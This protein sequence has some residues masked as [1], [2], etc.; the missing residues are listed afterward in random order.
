MIMQNYWREELYTVFLNLDCIPEQRLMTHSTK[1]AEDRV[2]L[3]GH[4]PGICDVNENVK[5][6]TSQNQNI[7]LKKRKI[8]RNIL[9]KMFILYFFN[10]LRLVSQLWISN[11]N[12][13]HPNTFWP[14]SLNVF[15][16]LF[17]FLNYTLI[18]ILCL[19]NDISLIIDRNFKKFLLK[20]S[21]IAYT[22]DPSMWETEAGSVSLRPAQSIQQD[23]VKA[24]ISIALI[25]PEE[26]GFVLEQQKD[27]IFMLLVYQH[28]LLNFHK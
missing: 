28:L 3:L 21:V 1:T 22:Q 8:T 19:L 27:F 5:N 9:M 20:P 14:T 11:S 6:Y 13:P 12:S 24:K 10:P 26:P 23:P 2:M 17:N 4:H 25:F 15:I 18:S 16:L 7:C